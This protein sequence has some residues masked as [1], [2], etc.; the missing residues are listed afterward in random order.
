MTL[1]VPGSLTANTQICK[2]CLMDATVPGVTFNAQ[3]TCNHCGIHDQ[4]ERAYPLGDEGR[5]RMHKIADEIRKAG[6]GKRYD[7]VVGVSGGRDTSYCLYVVKRELGL[8][9]PS[10]E[11]LDR[12]EHLG[13]SIGFP[14]LTLGVATG[15]L[16]GASAGASPWTGHTIF[17]LVAWLVYL[18]PVTLRV[19]RHERGPQPARGVVIGFLVLLFSYVGVRL[20]GVAS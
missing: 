13:L 3:G 19:V 14:L 20:L 6:K 18:I 8:R 16:W 9:L 15:F 11:S 4:L 17:L 1:G 7:C 5:K 12:A 10:L 2:R